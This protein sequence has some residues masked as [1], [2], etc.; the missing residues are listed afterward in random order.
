MGLRDWREQEDALAADILLDDIVVDEVKL[1]DYRPL[2]AERR[3]HRDGFI[4]KAYRYPDSFKKGQTV[5]VREKQTQ[6]IIF[7]DT[8]IWKTANKNTCDFDIV[9]IE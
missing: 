6:V 1:A 5:K 9:R 2:A 4:G 8:V 7:E 3:I